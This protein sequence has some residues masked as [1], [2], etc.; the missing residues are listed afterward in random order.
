MRNEFDGGV[1]GHARDPYRYDTP[2]ILKTRTV[3]KTRHSRYQARP[4]ESQFRVSH[5]THGREIRRRDGLTVF[6]NSISERGVPFLDVL[7]RMTSWQI[8]R[9]RLALATAIIPAVGLSEPVFF[10]APS[11][12]KNF[13]RYVC[14]ASQ[15]IPP[16]RFETSNERSFLCGTDRSE[17]VRVASE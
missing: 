6:R 8:A 12:C 11:S 2:V 10:C 9:S 17:I 13:A 1:E 15:L 7:R 4:V 16:S 3:V 5:L 14:D